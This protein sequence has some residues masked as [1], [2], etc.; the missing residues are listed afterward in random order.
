[1]ISRYVLFWQFLDDIFPP[2]RTLAFAFSKPRVEYM[3]TQR[4]PGLIV[5]LMFSLLMGMPL[6]TVAQD[7]TGETSDKEVVKVCYLNWGNQGGEHLPEK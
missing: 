3:R 7:S 1:V 5:T 2:N 4:H 6:S